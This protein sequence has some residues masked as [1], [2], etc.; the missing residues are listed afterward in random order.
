MTRK[1]VS[2]LFLMV[3]LM[4]LSIISC[5]RGEGKITQTIKVAGSTT[6]LPV[7][8]RAAEIFM[9]NHPGVTITINSGGSGVGVTSVAKGLADIGMIS[10]DIT[11]EEKKSFRDADFKVHPIGKDAVACVVSSEVYNAGIKSL[12]PERIRK[13][14]IGEI[15]NWKE[16]GGYDR[17]ILVVDKEFHRGTRHVFMGYIFGDENAKAPGADIITGSNNEEQ[18]KIGQS[19]SAIG[20]LSYAWINKDVMG[21]GIEVDGKV[22]EPTIE[23][24][25][26]GSYPIARDILLVI[27]GE[28]SGIV[29]EFIEF[30]L[31]SE[32]QRIVEENGYVSIKKG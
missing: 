21:L 18:S 5:S 6:V 3:L 8:S 25:K 22:I 2:I 13:I 1:G 24:I 7:V 11:Q 27:R 19:N 4:C 10:R 28:T 30:I 14:Y 23:N 17:D 32:G 29:K 15:R 31:S 26:N 12:S 9:K 20:M 16:I